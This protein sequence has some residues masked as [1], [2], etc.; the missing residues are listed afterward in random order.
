MCIIYKYIF[1]LRNKT[2]QVCVYVYAEVCV[3][4]YVYIIEMMYASHNLVNKR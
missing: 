4:F 1:F 2:M 3:N